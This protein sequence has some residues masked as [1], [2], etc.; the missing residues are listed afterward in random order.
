M[1]T[2]PRLK[3]MGSGS[4]DVVGPGDNAVMASVR[5]GQPVRWLDLRAGYP[6]E[7]PDPDFLSLRLLIGLPAAGRRIALE[8]SA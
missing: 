5:R 6:A 7:V 3:R 2:F 1:G 4:C 8:D